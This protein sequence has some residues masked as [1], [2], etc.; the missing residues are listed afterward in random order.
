[1]R[2]SRTL[3]AAAIAVALTACASTE[4]RVPE[5][6]L[7]PATAATVPGID[8]WWTQ[9]NDPQLTSLIEETLAANLDLRIAVARIEEARAT[10]T[11]PSRASRARRSRT[12]TGP[13]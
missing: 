1:M 11:R 8:R 12:A 10:A 7:P 13:A 4:T 6:E 3:L 5:V 9:F 2:T